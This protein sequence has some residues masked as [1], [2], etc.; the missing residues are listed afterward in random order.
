M[1][2]FLLVAHRIFSLFLNK[3]ITASLINFTDY[4]Q[5]RTLDIRTLSLHTNLDYLKSSSLSSPSSM[6]FAIRTEEAM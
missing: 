4:T 5:Y 3:L 6:V 1:K 2:G